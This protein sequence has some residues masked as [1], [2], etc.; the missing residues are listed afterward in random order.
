MNIIYWYITKKFLKPLI[1]ISFAFGFIV[2]ISEFFREMNFYMEQKTPFLVVLEYLSLNLPWWIIQVFAV[3][4]LLALLFS[5]GE[6]AKRNEI[7]ALKAAGINIWKIISLFMLLGFLI[8]VFDFSVREFIIPKIVVKAEYVRHV[9]IKKKEPNT[10]QS[11]HYNLI[12]SLP[13]NRRMS[14]A[15]LNIEN[16][17][18]RDIIIDEY[19]DNFYLKDNIVAGQAYYDGNQWV[20]QNGVERIFDDNHNWKEKYFDEKAFGI[21]VP[22]KDF[23]IEDKRYELMDLKEFKGYIQKKQMLGKPTIKEQIVYNTRFANVFCHLIVMMI[24]IPFA[25]GLGNKFGKI[26]SFTFALIFSFIYWS[27]QA[28][29]AS[30][31][32]NL[33]LS[34]FLAAWLPNFI[35]AIIGIL[36]FIKLK[37]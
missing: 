25:L 10:I 8:G 20:M 16:K 31:G 21:T 32:E 37:K 12:I 23:I 6:L 1:F 22:P 9:K 27:V 19:D 5:L 2:L 15:Y 11:E 17:Y 14:V 24:G 4:V 13:Y 33:I 29:C 30:L 26:I 3:S 28:V 36:L 34:V 35:F 18:M 7:T